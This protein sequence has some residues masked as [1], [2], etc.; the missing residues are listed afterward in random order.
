MPPL[1][2]VM[3]SCGDERERGYPAGARG[4]TLDPGGT[5]KYR[6]WVP[7]EVGDGPNL[8]HLKFTTARRGVSASPA[9]VEG[10]GGIH[11]HAEAIGQ[12][13]GQNTTASGDGE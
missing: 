4:A 6:Q 2:Q 5:P 13:T 3:S 8:S 7:S 9:S 12:K 1:K 11:G 10:K